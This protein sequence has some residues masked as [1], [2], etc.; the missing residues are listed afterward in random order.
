MRRVIIS[1]LATGQPPRLS[2]QRTPHIPITYSGPAY[3]HEELKPISL[4]PTAA[5]QSSASPP[6]IT[7]RFTKVATWNIDRQ[8]SYDGPIK[9]CVHGDLNFLNCAEPAEYMTPGTRTT[10]NLINT[11]DKAGYVLYVTTHCHT[12]IRQ[13]TLHTRLVSQR[14]SY[15]VRLYTF[16][17][18]GI[19]IHHTAILCLYAFQRGH[20]D[21]SI[22]IAENTTY[23]A[24]SPMLL[25]NPLSYL[26]RHFGRSTQ[27][28]CCSSWETFSIQYLT[29]HS[30]VWVRSNHHQQ[31]ISSRNV[32][33]T[34]ST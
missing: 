19:N 27:T 6:S 17:L 3:N 25:N 31:Q 28:S 21:H 26:L 18:Q 4:S 16:V 14:S 11:A 5:V 8:A 7:M 10:A 12:Y 30:I 13:A 9:A 1:T 20:R 22:A 33:N 15:N 34:P 29:L 23:T 32:F 24:Q 2:A